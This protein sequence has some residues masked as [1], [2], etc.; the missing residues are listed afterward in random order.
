MSMSITEIICQ[1]ESLTEH[2]ESMID[3][4]DPENIWR[5]DVEVLREVVK[6]L[7]GELSGENAATIIRQIMGKGGCEP[8]KSLQ[9]RWDA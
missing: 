4:G 7:K 2:C 6:K 8:E 1:L 9:K 5:D 3:K